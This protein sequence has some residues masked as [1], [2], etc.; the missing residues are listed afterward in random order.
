M[1]SID[2]TELAKMLAAPLDALE[3]VLR[4][5]AECRCGRSAS[6]AGTGHEAPRRTA[7]PRGQ[8]L[9]GRVPS[10]LPARPAALQFASCPN[11]TAR[12]ASTGDRGNRHQNRAN[13]S[14]PP[15]GIHC[16]RGSILSALSSFFAERATG[17]IGRP[18]TWLPLAAVP[19]A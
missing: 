11:A 9:G 19:A 10:L 6:S 7:P 2:I 3:R 4:E 13:D 12:R 14:R 16:R 5:A 18:A 15:G 1:A 17:T 8:P